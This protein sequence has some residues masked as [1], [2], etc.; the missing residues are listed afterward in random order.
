MYAIRSYY[1]LVG[2]V[3]AQDEGAAGLAGDKV[4]HQRSAQVADVDIAGGRRGEAGNG[5]GRNNFV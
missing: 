3:D 5:L 1:V 4:V 2:I